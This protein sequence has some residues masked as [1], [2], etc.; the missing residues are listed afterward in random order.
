MT[1]P[2]ILASNQLT[3]YASPWEYVPSEDDPTDVHSI[4]AGTTDNMTLSIESDRL[5]VRAETVTAATLR[6]YTA[7]GAQVEYRPLAIASGEE[8]I[9]IANLPTGIYVAHLISA[10]G[11]KCTLKFTKK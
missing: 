1:K 10:N 4:M 9:S 5:V 11:T 2:T 7:A 3:S 6:I 8:R